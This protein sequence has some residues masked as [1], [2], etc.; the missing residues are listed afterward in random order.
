MDAKT[1]N[2]TNTHNESAAKAKQKSVE[3]ALSYAAD[4]QRTESRMRSHDWKGD[5]TEWI[6]SKMQDLER[7]VPGEWK[8]EPAKNVTEVVKPTG[9]D[10]R[11]ESGTRMRD[12][13]APSAPAATTKYTLAKTRLLG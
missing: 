8:N 5:D 4:K 3:W 6:S 11:L 13:A 9:G 12:R 1:R 10:G 7:K 2:P